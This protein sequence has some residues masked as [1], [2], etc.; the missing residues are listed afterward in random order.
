MRLLQIV[1]FLALMAPT[2][3]NA[4]DDETTDEPVADQPADDG[5]KWAIETSATFPLVRIYILQASYAFWDH[6]EVVFGVGLQRWREGSI[7]PAPGQAEAYTALLGYRQYLWRGLHVE[8]MFF[9]AYN[10][11][12]SS[13]D[14]ETYPGLE[15]W[16]EAYVG[17]KLGFKVGKL[18]LFVTPQP[19]IGFSIARQNKWPG[20]EDVPIYNPI[21][22]PQ[23]L[24][25]IEL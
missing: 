17:Y 4:A 16:G 2:A 3:A 22:V 10:R 21:F 7:G 23:V 6:G 5:H 15:L 25:G 18:P 8:S 19:G 20:Y 11:F 9:P 1:S 12:H 14:G 24:V 13:I